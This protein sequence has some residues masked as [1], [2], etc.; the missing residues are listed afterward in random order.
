MLI[1]ER[2]RSVIGK[3]PIIR[4]EPITE[5]INR[6]GFKEVTVRSSLITQT[7]LSAPTV[8]RLKEGIIQRLQ[9]RSITMST[10]R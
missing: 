3:S 1:V 2:S 5:V 7:R 6:E 8:T 9:I 4:T 10:P